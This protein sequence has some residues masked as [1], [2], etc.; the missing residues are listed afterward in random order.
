MHRQRGVDGRGCWR[1]WPWSARAARVRRLRRRQRR[2]HRGRGGRRRGADRD[3][4]GRRER[5]PGDL[6]L[7]PLH[8]QGN[9]AGLRG[10]D[11]DLGQVRRGHQ[12]LRRVLREDAAVALR[13]RLRRPFADGRGRLAGEADVRPGLSAEARPRGARARVREPEPRGQAASERPQLG[14]LDPL[15][16]RDDRADREQEARPRYRLDLRHLRP[17]VPRADRGDQRA[18]RDPGPGD[19]VRG[20]RPRDGDHPAVARRDP[21]GQGRGRLGPDPQ[22]HRWRLCRAT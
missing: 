20:D 4:R 14:L 1:S 2:R 12:R 15:A 5:R 13:R 10:R 18:A 21:E 16:G 22:V 3:R 8:R 9:R 11:R 6:Q 19:E 17:A 7:G